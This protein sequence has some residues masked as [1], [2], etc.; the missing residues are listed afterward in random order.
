MLIFSRKPIG[1]IP[2]SETLEQALWETII[3]MMEKVLV[4]EESL[5]WGKEI[6]SKNF[7]SQPC[8]SGEM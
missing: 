2:M 1:G 5:L 3:R 7:L 8:R 6:M 4:G